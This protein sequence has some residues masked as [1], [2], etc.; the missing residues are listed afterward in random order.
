MG[1]KNQVTGSPVHAPER[2]K[3]LF[4]RE[5]RTLRSICRG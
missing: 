1:L 3:N 2:T 4:N 5:T